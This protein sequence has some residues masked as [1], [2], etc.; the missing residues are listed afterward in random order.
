[1]DD[2]R[3]PSERSGALDQSCVDEKVRP[4]NQGDKAIV[5]V[6]FAVARIA[7]FD[8]LPGRIKFIKNEC[9]R[10]NITCLKETILISF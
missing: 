4:T 5:T 3:V 10:E 6:V 7:L 9:K 1:M 8:V 2:A